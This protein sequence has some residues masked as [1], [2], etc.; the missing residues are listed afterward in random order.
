M[1]NFLALIAGAVITTSCVNN[2]NEKIAEL[3][4]L[5]QEQNELIEKQEKAYVA[6]Q[7]YNDFLEIM[8][9][10]NSVLISGEQSDYELWWD[11]NSENV[12]KMYTEKEG[13]IDVYVPVGS[14]KTLKTMRGSILLGLYYIE[15]LNVYWLDS[16]YLSENPIAHIKVIDACKYIAASEG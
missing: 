15:E 5:V 9:A 2:T 1:K 10:D 3:E 6:L 12:Y 13:M 4:T 11:V 14:Y 8:I 7:D 16:P